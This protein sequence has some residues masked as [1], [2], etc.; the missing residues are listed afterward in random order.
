MM[1]YELSNKWDPNIQAMYDQGSGVLQVFGKNT[2]ENRAKLTE[3]CQN[4]ID[5]EET[6]LLL[7][8]L[9]TA[10]N[11]KFTG[12]GWQ[13]VQKHLNLLYKRQRKFQRDTLEFG[14]TPMARVLLVQKYRRLKCSAPMPDPESDPMEL[15]LR[16]HCTLG[17]EPPAPI[18]EDPME[19]LL[20][21][22]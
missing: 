10:G 16:K 12:K 4:A 8:G 1:E 18:D 3:A 13:E 11:V 17:M 9:E 2:H 19:L 5:I 7:K 15:L 21:D 22:K 14:W 20:R 6:E